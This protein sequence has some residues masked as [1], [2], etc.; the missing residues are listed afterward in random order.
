MGQAHYGAL[1][2]MLALLIRVRSPILEENMNGIVM[3]TSKY[4]VMIG[5][6]LLLAACNKTD[7]KSLA[8]AEK[9]ADDEALNDG[10]IECALAGGKNFTRVCETERISGPAG[11]ILVIR[12]PNGGFRRFKVLTD[13]RGLAAAEGADPTS[14]KILNTG[15]IELSSGDDLYRLPA[16]IKS[17]PKAQAEPAQIPD[18]GNEQA[19]TAQVAG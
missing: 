17:E 18:A 10:K 19:D 4:A 3:Q 6:T 2:I 13:G 14:I 8:Q 12:N 1:H 5:A 11:Q 15:E 7:Q 9:A 16:Q